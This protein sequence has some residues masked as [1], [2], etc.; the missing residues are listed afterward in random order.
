MHSRSHPS[1]RR[2]VGLVTVAVLLAAA[3]GAV[4]AA[5]GEEIRLHVTVDKA[6]LIALPGEP[7]SA[8]SVTNAKIADVQVVTPTQLLVNGKATGLTSLVVFYPRNRVQFF[9]LVVDPAPVVPVTAPRPSPPHSVLVH[10]ADKLTSHL[11]VRDGET[12]WV[13]LG[14]VKNEIDEDRSKPDVQKAK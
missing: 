1:S 2:V 10:R 8:V 6:Q 13:E 3:G 9:D 4:P 11:F 5:G 7:L 12:A 14:K